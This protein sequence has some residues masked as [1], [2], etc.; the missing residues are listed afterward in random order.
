MGERGKNEPGLQVQ[1]F[2]ECTSCL[3][4]SQ[5][6]ELVMDGEGRGDFSLAR[7]E[8]MAHD[9]MLWLAR[10]MIDHLVRQSSSKD[11][12]WQGQRPEERRVNNPGRMQENGM[13]AGDSRR[14][15]RMKDCMCRVRCIRVQGE[16]EASPREAAAAF[17][18]LHPSRHIPETL[19][20]VGR[21]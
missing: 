16:S 6:G 12:E 19:P 9:A 5:F 10:L 2:T 20:Q 11:G 1:E 17:Q 7:G 18:P 3:A 13:R 8:S 14:Q 15:R 4:I 21:C